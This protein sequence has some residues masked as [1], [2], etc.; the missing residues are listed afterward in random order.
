MI[1][2]FS[3]TELIRAW[4]DGISS[5]TDQSTPAEEIDAFLR[6]LLDRLIDALGQAEFSSQPGMEIGSRLAGRGFTGA[7][8]L[9]RTVEI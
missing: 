2:P 1:D 4:S 7:Q 9:G 6:G 3:R 8:S 5:T